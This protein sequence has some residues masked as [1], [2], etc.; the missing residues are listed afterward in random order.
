[1][2]APLDLGL[3]EDITHTLADIS[4]EDTVYRT[5]DGWVVKVKTLYEHPGA[6]QGGVHG[7][8]LRFHLSGSICGKDGKALR[9]ADGSLAVWTL[10]QTAHTKAENA[11][12]IDPGPDLEFQRWRCA[13]EAIRAEKNHALVLERAEGAQPGLATVAAFKARRAAETS[14][15]VRS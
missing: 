15:G 9:R 7:N 11:S 12:A 14:T 1:M 8:I 2:S 5:A 10:G 3:P 6:D 4:P 13:A